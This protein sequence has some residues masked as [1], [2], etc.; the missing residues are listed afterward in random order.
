MRYTVEINYKG[1]LLWRTA[2]RDGTIV[3]AAVGVLSAGKPKYF[4]TEIA[5]LQLLRQ[6][7]CRRVFFGGLLELYQEV[8]FLCEG[9]FGQVLT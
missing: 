2:K 4:Y 1:L 3:L 5:H 7:L 8:C 9:A 6:Q